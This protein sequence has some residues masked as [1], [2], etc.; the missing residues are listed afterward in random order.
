MMNWILLRIISL[1]FENFTFITHET[2]T[3]TQWQF[4][5]T[6]L[7]NYVAGSIYKFAL[8]AFISN[9]DCTLYSCSRMIVNLPSK[10]Y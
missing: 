8:F 7:L 10:N 9:Y 2:T 6:E 1:R 5:S 3:T 4:E